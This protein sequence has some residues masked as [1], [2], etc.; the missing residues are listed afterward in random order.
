[1]NRRVRISLALAGFALLS[2]CAQNFRL[3]EDGK[4]HHGVLHQASKTMEAS[5]DG[6]RYSGPASQGMGVGF[7]QAFYNGRVGFGTT[8]VA[9]GQ[10]QG[11]LT[12][13]SGKV[14]RCQFQAALGAGQGICQDNAG[15]T[16]DLIIGAMP[17]DPP[18]ASKQTCNHGTFISNGRCGG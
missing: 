8:T 13:A 2:G 9:S 5:I 6:E 17:G 11:L 10:W 1:M 4:V 15:R 3:L 14:I 16:F 18:T 7:G 12:N